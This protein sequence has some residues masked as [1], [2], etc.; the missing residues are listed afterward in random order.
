MNNDKRIKIR[1]K[2]LSDA[3]EDYAWQ[4]DPELARLDATTALEMSYPHYL[5]EYTFELCYPSPNRHEFGIETLDG[6][7]IGNC[8]YYNVN[9][10]EGKAELGIM[11]GNRDYW[12]QGYG[13]EVIN[14]LLGYIFKNTKLDRIYL[15][16]LTWNIRA[17]K[18]F[19]KCGFIEC[20]E[21]NREGYTFLM[22]A[23]HREEFEK[24]CGPVITSDTE[25]ASIEQKA[26]RS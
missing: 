19:K 5:S 23:I 6:K 20:G 11:I 10:S 13:Y 21:V 7:H 16:T 8:V 4:T 15:T 3:K 22:M 2:R 1:Y 24:L 18:C 9:Q 26:S 14:A 17:Q 12:S 25:S